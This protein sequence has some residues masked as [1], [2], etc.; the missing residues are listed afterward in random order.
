VTVSQAV[1]GPDPRTVILTTSPIAV[2]QSA[3]LPVNGVVDE[4]GN[5]VAANSQVALFAPASALR[6]PAFDLVCWMAAD[7]G[8]STS[9]GQ[10]VSAWTDQAG[11][12]APHDLEGVQGV[13]QWSLVDFFPSGWNPVI[14]WN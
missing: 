1:M 6:P 10:T 13:P 3:T 2:G 5:A 11:G 14:Q 4:A 9:D 12:N 8:V 7:A